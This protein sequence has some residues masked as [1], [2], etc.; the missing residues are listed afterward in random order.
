MNNALNVC[1]DGLNSKTLFAN[2]IGLGQL[3]CNLNLLSDDDILGKSLISMQ[4]NLITSKNEASDRAIEDEKRTWINTGYALFADTLRQNNDN[5]QKLTDEVLKNI[6]KYVDANQGA[7]FVIEDDNNKK[8]VLKGY[9]VYAWDRKKYVNSNFLLG[10]GLIGACA[11][12]GETIFLTEIPTDFITISSGLGEANPNCIALIPLKHNSQVVGVLEIASFSMLE[13]HQIEFLEKISESIASTI[14]S[15]KSNIQTKTLLEQSQQQAEEMI[16]QEEELRQNIE[17]LQA[18]K[19]EMDRKEKDINELISTYNS[20]VMFCEYDFN[21]KIINA[22][23]LFCQQYGYLKEELIG[24]HHTFLIQN[25]TINSIEYSDLFMK[26]M[27]NEDLAGSIR[28]KSRE[29]SSVITKGI[30]RPIFNEN[31]QPVK[32]IELLVSIN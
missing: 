31:N 22:N 32:I 13:F 21:G 7:M 24:K 18:T 14:L 23:N 9:S 1:I 16:A 10:E 5:I 11:L 17:E 15:V 20:L 26:L 30:I 29:N 8:S 27:K 12:E 6:V 4:Q 3:D 19:E 28:R 2:S 25:T